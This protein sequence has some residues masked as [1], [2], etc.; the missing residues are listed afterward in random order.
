MSRTASDWTVV[1][2]T[3]NNAE[4]LT[5]WWTD[6]DLRGARW[7]VVDNNSSDDS[8]RMASTLGADVVQL[9]ENVG[10]SKANNVALAKAT[11]RY[12]A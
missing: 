7:I 8:A 11:T 4:E 10:F 6:T 9:A 12:I 2:V 5:R 1:T 3:Y